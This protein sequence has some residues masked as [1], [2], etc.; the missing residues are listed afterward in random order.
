MLIP[1]EDTALNVNDSGGSG[2][3]VVY[4]NGAYAN[5]KHF[6]PVIAALGN[7]EF[8]HITFDAR[9]RGKSKQSADYSFAAGLRDIDAVLA[10]TGAERPILVGWSYGATLAAYWAEQNPDRIAGAV[11]VD[12]AMPYGLTGEEGAE[13][14]RQLFSKMRYLLPLVRPFGLAARMS[15]EEHIDVNIEINGIAAEMAPVLER[16]TCP[17]RYVLATGSS[18]GGGEEEMEAARASLE[19]VLAVNSNLQIAAKVP[20]NHSHILRKDF[21]A[22]AD[23]VRATAS[24]TR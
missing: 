19:P 8:R 7:D 24:V 9:A 5:W 6:K 14:I 12:G 23:A 13:R 17:F 21:A 3:P 22:V 4:L 11:A 18:L 1:T 15:L 16:I 20:S 10:A 2:R